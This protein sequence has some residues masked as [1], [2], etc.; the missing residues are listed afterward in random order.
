[1]KIFISLLLLLTFISCQ[2]AK[3]TVSSEVTIQ[4][5]LYA[6]DISTL[7][8]DN[9]RLQLDLAQNTIMSNAT[10]DQ[11]NLFRVF[12]IQSRRYL[13]VLL[14]NPRS[15]KG[16]T[17][18]EDLVFNAKDLII[19]VTDQSYIV[20]YLKSLEELVKNLYMF[21]GG[22]LENFL[23]KFQFTKENIDSLTLIKDETAADFISREND[24]GPYVGVDSFRDKKDGTSAVVTPAFSLK[25]L[26]YSIRFEY[27]V[28]FYSEDARNLNLIKFYVGEDK[29]SLED[30]EW[31]DL[32]VD[33]AP[34]AG[35]FSEP[36]TLSPKINLDFRDTNVRFK[37]EYSSNLAESF[38][39]ALNLFKFEVIEN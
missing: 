36:P 17:S 38:F 25:A 21:Q 33:I 31:I 4:S 32:S 8:D 7:I 5:G 26:K 37:V 39:P 23:V 12:L 20:P 30:I 27:L 11:T 35:S 6:S 9:N 15:E 2:G 18:L 14:D 1:M 28:R 24:S 13:I 3:D 19:T 29:E 16:L 10:L 34:D 22:T